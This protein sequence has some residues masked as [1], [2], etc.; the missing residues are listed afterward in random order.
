MPKNKSVPRS[1]WP[2]K[3][4]EVVPIPFYMIGVDIVGPL[5]ITRSGNKY[6]LSVIEYYTKYAEASALPNPEA[7]TIV[8]VVEQFLRDMDWRQFCLQTKE[9]TFNRIL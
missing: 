5:K 6:T 7:E 2:L 4:I 3:S 9:G 8:R 1:R